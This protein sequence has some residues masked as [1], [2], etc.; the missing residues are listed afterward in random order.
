MAD[1]QSGFFFVSVF[2]F[3]PTFG[4]FQLDRHTCGASKRKSKANNKFSKQQ[5]L[6][7]V[8]KIQG[9]TL[10]PVNPELK[11]KIIILYANRQIGIKKKR[12]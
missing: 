2:W 7:K 4:F 3:G 6:I 1:G 8:Y 12:Y 5:S 9:D 11:R 10:N